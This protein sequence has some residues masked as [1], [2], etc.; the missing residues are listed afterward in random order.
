MEYFI[1]GLFAGMGIVG[2]VFFMYIHKYPSP[3]AAALKSP[4]VEKGSTPSTNVRSLLQDFTLQA[5]ED[6]RL[7]HLRFEAMRAESNRKHMEDE[8]SF[9]V[10]KV[11]LG[12]RKGTVVEYCAWLYGYLVSGGK[13]SH[14]YDYALRCDNF[15]IATKSGT[16]TPLCGAS[17]VMIIAETGVVIT[18]SGWSHNSVYHMDGFTVNKGHFVPCYSNT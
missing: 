10:D 7:D 1:W 5:R 11:K 15:Y 4:I 13:V 6:A 3:S 9:E 17:S 8:R 16:L 12:L 18:E 2:A 14:Y